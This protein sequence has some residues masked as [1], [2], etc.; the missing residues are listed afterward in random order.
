MSRKG[1]GERETE[2]FGK[3]EEEKGKEKEKGI[4]GFGINFGVKRRIVQ[5][6]LMC[7]RKGI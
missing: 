1:K 6:I 3:G 7:E 5:R 4:K 2:Q